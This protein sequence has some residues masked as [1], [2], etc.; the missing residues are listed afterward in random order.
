MDDHNGLREAAFARLRDVFNLD[1]VLPENAPLPEREECEPLVRK[2]LEEL[3]SETGESYRDIQRY[4]MLEE[5]D[6]CWKE[7]LRNM[8]A[9]RDGIGLR[10]Y[11]QRDPKQ[12]YKREGFEMFQAMLGNMREDTLRM[13]TRLVM[14]KAAEQ[15]AAEEA[16]APGQPQSGAQAAARPSEQADD[17]SQVTTRRE[18][19]H[20]EQVGDLSYS[21]GEAS[22]R[23]KAEPKRREEP[24]V[25]RNDPC[26][27]GSGKKYKKCCGA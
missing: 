14:R 17:Q 15:Q 2:V 23:P 13:L 4:F 22:S 9:L 1:R 16:A 6:R 8:D 10:G 24:R 26:P 18:F 11:G 25:G 3:R 21:G 27:C 7:H 20:K 5:L 19:K 12:E